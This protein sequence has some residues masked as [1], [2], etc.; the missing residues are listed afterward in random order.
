V[1]VIGPLIRSSV[2]SWLDLAASVDE[3]SIRFD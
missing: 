2:L 3:M 1:M